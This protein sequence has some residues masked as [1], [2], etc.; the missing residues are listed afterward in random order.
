MSNP[1]SGSGIDVSSV[2]SQIEAGERAPETN[3]ENEQSTIQTQESALGSINTDLSSLLT[4]VQALTDP[5]GALAIA[6][7]DQQ[8]HL[9]PQRN[10]D[11]VGRHRQSYDYGDEAGDDRFLVQQLR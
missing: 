2:V 1:L 9:G 6:N 5:T 3:L 11:L 8:R 10:R 4:S 7:R